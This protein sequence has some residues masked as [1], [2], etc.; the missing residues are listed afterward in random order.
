MPIPMGQMCLLNDCKQS[1]KFEKEGM[2]YCAECL[3]KSEKAIANNDL[4]INILTNAIAQIDYLSRRL[5][6]KEFTF[7]SFS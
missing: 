1:A 6:A 5:S 4:I 7:K 3:D 2:Y